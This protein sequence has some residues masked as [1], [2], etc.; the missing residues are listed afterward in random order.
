MSSL[1][2]TYIRIKGL[3]TI[4]LFCILNIAFYFDFT[5]IVLGILIFG[6]NFAHISL[7]NY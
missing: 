4:I 1:S 2:K 3:F 5:R 7:I 6:V